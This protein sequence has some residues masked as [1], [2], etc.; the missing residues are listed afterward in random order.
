VVRFFE[1]FGTYYNG[2][3]NEFRTRVNYGPTMRIS[4]ATVHEWDRFRF[5]EGIFNVHVG[6][7]NTSYSFSRFLTTSLLFQVNSDKNPVSVNFRV[8]WNYRPDSDLFLIYNLGNQFNSLAAGNPILT[9]EQRLTV[10]YTYSF[11]K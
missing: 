11:L 7:L 10:K 3:L 2:R 1:R 8:R 4:I 9:R 6:S 5:P